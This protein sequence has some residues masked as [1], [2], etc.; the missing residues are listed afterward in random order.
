MSVWSGRQLAT[1]IGVFVWGIGIPATLQGVGEPLPDKSNPW[2]SNREPF[3]V[4]LF[5]L[6]DVGAHRAVTVIA[7]VKNP[8]A[9]RG[10]WRSWCCRVVLRV[11]ILAMPTLTLGLPLLIGAGCQLQPMAA[12]GNVGFVSPAFIL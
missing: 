1:G 6:Q 9:Q 10:L 12:K 5:V 11:S 2:Q 7:P 4:P 3:S 8:A